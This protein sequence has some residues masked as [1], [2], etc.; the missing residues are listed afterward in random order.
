MGVDSIQL[1]DQKIKQAVALIQQLRNENFILRKK[2]GD[3]ETKIKELEEMLSGLKVNQESIEQGLM[4]AI[5]EL[6]K[7][8]AETSV[9]SQ[10]A[11]RS[12]DFSS[13]SNS[14]GSFTPQS[15]DEGPAQNANT[16]PDLDIF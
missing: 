12:A 10:E 13:G 3:Y 5:S 8:E 4:N 14:I 7:L 11:P 1:L 9:P 15:E 2:L 16:D 6:E